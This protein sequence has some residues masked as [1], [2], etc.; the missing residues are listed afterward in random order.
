[1]KIQ[2]TMLNHDPNNGGAFE[3]DVRDPGIP[4]GVFVGTKKVSPILVKKGEPP[5]PIVCIAFESNPD[6][7]LRRRRFYL[8]GPGAVLENPDETVTLDFVGFATSERFGIALSVYEEPIAA[9]EI[10]AAPPAE[11]AQEA[12]VQ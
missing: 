9:V 5:T 7:P 4:R 8:L 12:V 11:L 10:V 2:M 6:Q 1:M 3:A